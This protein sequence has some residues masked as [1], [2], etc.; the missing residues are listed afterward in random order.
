MWLIWWVSAR[1][2]WAETLFLLWQ[3]IEAECGNKKRFALIHCFLQH[4]KRY[5]Y[6]NMASGTRSMACRPFSDHFYCLCSLSRTLGDSEYS[7]RSVGIGGQNVKQ[8]PASRCCRKAN[9]YRARTTL[10]SRMQPTLFVWCLNPCTH[11]SL[12]VFK[13]ACVCGMKEMYW[14]RWPLYSLRS[15]SYLNPF[16]SLFLGVF[17]IFF[18]IWGMIV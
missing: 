16:T 14:K 12:A 6:C 5:T 10:V 3:N 4:L 11:V 8:E 13:N 9:N 7:A 1:A 17:C 18:G 15:Q 2:M